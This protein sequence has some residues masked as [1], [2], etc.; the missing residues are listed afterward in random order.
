MQ[1]VKRKEKLP[2]IIEDVRKFLED[3]NKKIV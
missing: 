1:L 2:E 3:K